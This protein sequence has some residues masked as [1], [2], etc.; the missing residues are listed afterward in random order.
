MNRI[1]VC[2]LIFVAPLAIGDDGNPAKSA[3]S[4]LFAPPK[5]DDAVARVLQSLSDK[6][7]TDEL[8][9]KI[10]AVWANVND[11]ASADSI[12][13][14]VVQS[15]AVA[16]PNVMQLIRECN[17]PPSTSTVPQIEL[18]NQPNHSPFFRANVGLYLGRYLVERRL[19]DEA[20]DTLKSIDERLVVDPASLFFF[21]AVAAQGMLEIK[22]ALAAIDRLL[23]NTEG[24]P[25]RYS[26]L[27]T[28]M[29]TELKGFEEK[30]LDEIARLMSDSERRLDLGRAG[31]KVQGVQERIV[32]ILDELIKKAE[33]QQSGGG[34]GGGSGSDEQGGQN[35]QSANPA[36]DSSIKGAEA[37][38]ESD[39]KKFDN[40]GSWGNLNEKDA[41]KAKSEL[42]KHFPS[43]YEQAIEKYTKKLAAR[44]AKKK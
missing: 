38:G 23:E 32:S 6:P 17:S 13:E 1:A 43:H 21:R 34:G 25:P 24:V 29:Q 28:M 14:A 40:R 36:N 39:K 18:L 2:F 10:E 22:P 3:S 44:A 20:W 11:S 8:R 19:F 27:A 12:L 33:Q 37:P 41:A 7:L 31:E 42:N 26:V 5:P 15:F 16:D 4:D 9:R 30:S 35:N